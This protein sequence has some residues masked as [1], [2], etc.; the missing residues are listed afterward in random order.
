VL[1]G[2]S[3]P[4]NILRGLEWLRQQGD[5]ASRVLVVT[6]DLPFLT[7]EAVTG[8]LDACPAAAAVSVP[9]HE[10]TA[11]EA[12]F[13]SFDGEYVRLCDGE[14]TMG[15]LFVLDPSAILAN[16]HHVDRVFAARK[17]QV[18]MALLLGLPFVLRWCLRR[19][20]VEHVRQRCSEILGCDGAVVLGCDPALAF[21]IDL[22]S[23]L[24]YARGQS[25]AEACAG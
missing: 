15:C 20:G 22:P 12:R 19:L 25:A 4:D 9:I 18:G 7:P 5:L 24:R 11:F 10:R 2:E 21:D 23:E 14:W 3:G 13:P 17:S 1:E 6:T 8:F 16:R